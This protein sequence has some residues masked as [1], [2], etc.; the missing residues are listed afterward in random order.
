MKMHMKQN[1]ID[2]C[3]IGWYTTHTH[4]ISTMMMIASKWRSHIFFLSLY[5]WLV[6]SFHFC[7]MCVC[8]FCSATVKI[9][10]C[11]VVYVHGGNSKHTL[12]L[13]SFFFILF[14]FFSRSRSLSMFLE[15][16]HD[17]KNIINNKK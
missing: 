16:H 4:T 5:M 6:F 9:F 7:N 17:L 1:Q 13:M 3:C 2:T 10:P 12:I 14:S 15:F 11:S 8:V